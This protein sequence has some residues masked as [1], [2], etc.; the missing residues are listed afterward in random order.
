M[1][2]NSL[3]YRISEKVQEWLQPDN[4]SLKEAI[5]R[6]V[7]DGLFAEHDIRFQIRHLKESV[8]QP[9]LQQWAKKSGLKENSLSGQRVLALHAG[10]LPLVGF[11]DILGVLLTGATY[12]GKLSRKDPWIL[13]DFLND[14]KNS[15]F[16]ERV[17]YSTDPDELPKQPADAVL[18]AGST[19]SVYEV[20]ARLIKSR[21]AEVGTP[22][23][24]RMA[25]FSIAHID[26]HDADTMRDLIEAVFR[27]GGSGCRSVAMVVAPFSLRSEKCTFTDYVEEFWLK[28]PQHNK[29]DKSLFHRYAYNRAIGREQAW[30]DDF[31]IEESS[32]KPGDQFVLHWK[33][34]G[35]E[36]FKSL[37][38]KHR[39]GLQAIYS[40]SLIAERVDD[41]VIEPLSTAQKPPIW[42]KPDGTDII[43]WLQDRV[44]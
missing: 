44:S 40:N 39:N 23:L 35:V 28:N 16:S 41:L 12:S 2:E 42:W 17:N 6:T 38:R 30:L 7:R 9:N 27:Y 5:E 25:H 33:K 18:F 32:K 19:D 4:Q 10:N 36:E 14:L 20:R 29:P 37:V 26:N 24:A 34:G 31:L 1:S 21:L 3:I 13:A 11:Q 8:T 43:K 22:F 15:E